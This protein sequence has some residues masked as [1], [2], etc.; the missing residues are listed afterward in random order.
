MKLVAPSLAFVL[1]TL[2]ESSLL[3]LWLIV[4][5][6]F[7]HWLRVLSLCSFILSMMMLLMLPS[8]SLPSLSN[9][10]T[11]GDPCGMFH[12]GGSGGWLR[13]N[14]AS[15]STPSLPS[16]YCLSLLGRRCLIFFSFSWNLFS[17]SGP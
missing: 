8:I 9:T 3:V 7:V 14:L 10:I 2:L 16:L 12:G 5:C 15:L 4:A 17:S 11:S 6:P 1:V 13:P